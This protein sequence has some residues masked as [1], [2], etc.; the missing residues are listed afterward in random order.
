MAFLGQKCHLYCQQ[1]LQRVLFC[2]EANQ[3][4]TPI[5]RWNPTTAPAAT[6]KRPQTHQ[7]CCPS[8]IELPENSTK[9]EL[10][11]MRN[12]KILLDFHDHPLVAKKCCCFFPVFF[13][14]HIANIIEHSFQRPAS[15]HT[16]PLKTL[17]APTAGD[18]C[19][20]ARNDDGIVSNSIR[21]E[22]IA[23]IFFG[24]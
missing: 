9:V 13:S 6:T 7:R 17:R 19:S 16:L 14:A 8:Q 10:Y 18:P 21:E 12:E 15:R 23:A 22:S 5:G 3:S 11:P 2:C 24:K 20:K 1:N 4:K